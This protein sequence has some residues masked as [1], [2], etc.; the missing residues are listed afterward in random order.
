MHAKISAN[1][2]G[3][4][5]PIVSAIIATYNR[6]HIVC[7]A[8]DSIL[9]QTYPNIEIIVV[10][11]GSKD[12]TQEKIKKYGKK[13]RVICQDNSGPAAAWNTGITAS[14]GEI[15]SFLGSDDIW[16][17]T[18]IERQVDC[19][20]QAG[21]NIP[22]SIANCWLQ[23]ADGRGTTSFKNARLVAP[24]GEGKWL[25]VT[26][27][28]AT[29]FVVFGQTIAI[30]RSAIRNVGLFD[31]SLRYLEDY[32]L[33]IRLAAL[34]PWGFVREPLV[35]WRQ[36]AAD[37]LSVE[38]G[39]EGLRV[40]KTSIAAR[41]RVLAALPSGE[42]HRRTKYL[43]SQTLKHSYLELW[44]LQQVDS[45]VKWRSLFGKLGMFFAHLRFYRLRKSKHYP[46]MITSN[47]EPLTP[48]E[49][50]SQLERRS[51]QC[52]VGVE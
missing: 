33:A 18:F 26:E 28:L 2:L 11:D 8:I 13:I 4:D 34:G 9:N 50:G 46:Q 1:I 14:K 3:H 19:L 21:G 10:D 17:P 29:R 32:D 44:A 38:A 35:V 51:E 22:C 42:N 7:E 6:E 30:R 41:E 24:L 25:N 52:E 39:K 27:V 37:S 15:I 23:F 12:N 20:K 45:G 49:A 43:L 5:F 31:E 36:S 40:L 16:L 48:L 47:F